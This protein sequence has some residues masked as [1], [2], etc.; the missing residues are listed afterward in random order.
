MQTERITY[1]VDLKCL[2]CASFVCV[3]LLLSFHRCVW[4]LWSSAATLQASSG[5]HF[6]RGPQG[7]ISLEE[8]EMQGI[9]GTLEEWNAME[10]SWLPTCLLGIHLKCIKS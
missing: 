1:K 8:M 3:R 5:Q 10:Y 2:G 9:S 6:P 4:M 7:N